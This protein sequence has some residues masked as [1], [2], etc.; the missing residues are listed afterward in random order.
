MMSLLSATCASNP[1]NGAEGNG[2]IPSLVHIRDITV[3]C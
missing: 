1:V 3:L 2:R